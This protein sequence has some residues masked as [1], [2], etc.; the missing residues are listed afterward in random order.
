M[1]ASML[2]LPALAQQA[3]RPQPMPKPEYYIIFGEMYSG[4]YN[5]AGRRLRTFSNTAFRDV[6]GNFLDSVCYWTML[7]ENYYRLG[8]YASAIEQYEAAL[9]LY[10]DL[11]QWPTRTQ[12]PESLLA[13]GS[14]SRRATEVPWAAS[15][16]SPNYGKFDNR[17]LVMLGQ[18]DAA[19]EAAMRGGGVVDPARWRSVDMAEV[20]RCVSLALYRRQMIKGPTCVIDPYTRTLSTRLIGDGGNTIPSAWQGVAKGLAL[21]SMED[22]SRAAA[23]LQSSLQISGRD[24]PLTPVALLMLGKITARA[25]N[26]DAAQQ[27]FLEASICAAA[28][29]QYDMVEESLRYAT[30]IHSSSRTMTPYPVLEAA[31]DWA[32]KENK[33]TLQ[34]SLLINSAMVS[35]ES[36]N[37]Q[38][39]SAALSKA[40]SEMS[41]NDLRRT[42][43]YTQWLYAAAMTAYIDND[44]RN[45]DKQF[46][47]F[48]EAARNTSRWLFQIGMADNAVREGQVTDRESELLYD[49]LLNEPTDADWL[50]R[51]EETM[52]FVATPHYEPMERWFEITLS[53]K[54]EEKAIGIAELI[55][56]QRFFSALPLGGRL[57]SLRWVLEA[58]EEALG[59]TA[60]GQR[61]ALMQRFPSWKE[62]SD[63]A[64]QLRNE[65]QQ[66]PVSPAANTD[67][68]TRQ[69]KLLTDL[70]GV[71][72]QQETM[73]RKLALVREPVELAFPR[74]LTIPE[75]QQQLQPNQTIV[76]ML[77][78]GQRYYVMHLGPNRYSFESTVQA[79][80]LER[81]INNLLKQINVGDKSAIL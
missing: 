80:G 5:D 39:A 63:R 38:D 61:D 30:L 52:A 42:D 66:L 54:A 29:E 32:K 31:I 3:A 76:S 33:D 53:R 34:A 8:D 79:R 37:T 57:L 27:L 21:A 11:Q 12:F 48:L 40:R 22:D 2:S 65:L 1:L 70:A 46:E 14:A 36:G 44:I 47:S 71:V 51:P 68:R 15:A 24:H 69:K 59:E 45:G 56:R 75:I 18:S 10:M 58:P 41:R 74:P 50:L 49:V 17:M 78:I 55:R 7:G 72:D 77:K 13:D 9:G 62:L 28:Y 26:L 20:M 43:L 67:E 16:R 23:V 60:R 19:N 6:N 64:R 25:Q 4:E 35:A 73:I 81:A